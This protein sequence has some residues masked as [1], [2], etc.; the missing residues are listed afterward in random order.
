M[1]AFIA[2]RVGGIRYLR[3]AV[4]DVARDEA[5]PADRRALVERLLAL[6]GQDRTAESAALRTRLVEYAANVSDTAL[7]AFL[8]R[9]RTTGEDWGYEAPDPVARDLSRLALDVMLEPGSAVEGAA[10]L[11]GARGRPAILLP[12]HLAFVD[13][14]ALDALLFRSGLSDVL[15]GLAVL[16]GPKVFSLPLRRVASLCF[17]TVKIPQSTSRATGEAVMSPREVARISAE[18]IRVAQSRLDAGERLLVFV[19]GSRSRNAR[20]ERA[21]AGVTRYL[22][23]PGL[24]LIPVGLAGTEKIVAIGDESLHPARA[25]ARFGAPIDAA[26]LLARCK[27][28][29]QL[30][31]DVVGLRIASLLPE[32]YRGVYASA[33]P[34]LEPAREIAESL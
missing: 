7:A 4:S 26:L 22:E 1:C 13:A 23:H 8:G 25:T 18:S 33:D 14:N 15:G 29:R 30:V 21:L 27:H 6:M 19:E 10:A 12:N 9:L 5:L 3:Q 2:R 11:H 34:A 17:G 32:S 24:L 16:V 20:L 28:R 31:M